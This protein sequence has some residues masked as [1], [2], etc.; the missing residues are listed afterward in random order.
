VREERLAGAVHTGA[1]PTNAI[2]FCL[3]QASLDLRDID[4]VAYYWQPWRGIGR[5]AAIAL[6]ALPASLR[7]LAPTTVVR[8]TP[9]TTVRQALVPFTLARQFGVPRRFRFVRHHLAHLYDAYFTSP[10]TLA[11][12]V[13]MDFS[14]EDLSTVAALGRGSEISPFSTVAYPHSLGSFY[15]AMTQYLGFTPIQD[16]YKVMGLA[17]YGDE[18]I[19]PRLR[20][21]VSLLPDGKFKIDLDYFVHQRGGESLFSP[22]LEELLGPR[23]MSAIPAATARYAAVAKA[24]QMVLEDACLH[25]AGHAL[26]ETGADDVCLAGGVAL[27]GVMVRRLRQELPVKRVFVPPSPDDA[28]TSSGAALALWHRLN[29]GGRTIPATG[30]LSRVGPAFSAASARERIESVPSLVVEEYPDWIEVVA[31]AL[32]AGEIVGWFQGPAEFGPRAL[33]GR[34]ILADPGRAEMNTRISDTI[35]SR[36]GFRPFAASVSE[37][38]A[39]EYFELSEAAPY[40]SEVCPVVPTARKLIPA[41]THVDG[42]CRPQTVSRRIDETFWRLLTAFGSLTGYPVLLNTSFNISGQAMVCTPEQA[43]ETFQQTPLSL[44]AIDG[45]IVRKVPAD[46]WAAELGAGVERSEGVGGMKTVAV[47]ERA[48]DQL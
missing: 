38:R 8:G 43:I 44:L 33:G 24:T 36:E 39:T 13:A 46:R 32:A 42:T 17:A 5:R 7:M 20:S 27:N 37:E 30:A 1:F 47:D 34:S 6:S 40:M 21:S 12:I 25:V 9:A 10:F 4:G 41:V 11:A 26:E 35:K 3:D 18:S 19:Y 15:S 48:D 45:L 22:M 23:R 28:G 16:E 29:G 31:G 2:E 14:G